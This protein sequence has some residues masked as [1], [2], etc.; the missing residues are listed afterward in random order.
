MVNAKACSAG[1]NDCNMRFTVFH[2]LPA[3][4]CFPLLTRAQPVSDDSLYRLALAHT[5]DVYY[6]RS[7]D[8]SPVFNGRLYTGYAFSF[9]GG[10]PFFDSAEFRT[11]RIVYDGI[12]F[13]DISLLYDDLSEAVITRDQGYWM[14]LVNERIKSFSVAG[15]QFI[16][17]QEDSSNRDLGGTGFYELLYQGHSAV[18]KK[19][20]KKI[21]EELSSS[22]GILRYIDESWRYYIKMGSAYFPVKSRREL[23]GIFSDHKNEVAQF[24]RKN[25]LNYH[26]NREHTI[27]AA[28][29]YYDQITK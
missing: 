13:N 23:L 12:R 3:F 20:V 9:K 26:K 22:E 4:F 7:G 14:Q 15:H 2:L 8:Q 18:I 27:T 19:T 29:A 25:R 24:M 16:R 28:T 21:R 5:L 17:I 11:G 10:S 6:Q 1:A